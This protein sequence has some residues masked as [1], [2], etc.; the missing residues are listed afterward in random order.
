MVQC[1][2]REESLLWIMND[3]GRYHSHTV[4][5]DLE[6]CPETG[7]GK[8]SGFVPGSRLVFTDGERCDC[9]CYF[10]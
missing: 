5:E 1:F 7:L 9:N 4:I 8:L 10:A 3:K 2:Q 6:G